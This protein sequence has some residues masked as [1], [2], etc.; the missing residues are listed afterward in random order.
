MAEQDLC[1]CGHPRAAHEHYRRGSDCGLCGAQKCAAFTVARVA[2]SDG[3]TVP[4]KSP[5]DPVV[6]A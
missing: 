4:V 3:E 5:Y 1:G 2:Q 6:G